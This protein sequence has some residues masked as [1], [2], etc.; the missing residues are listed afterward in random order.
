MQKAV[1]V[2]LGGM[3]AV[4]GVSYQDVQALA[5]ACSDENNLCVAA[6]DNAD[7]QVVL[8]GHMAAIDKAVEIASEF[9][10]KR[11]IKITGQ[12]TVS[13]PVN[14]AGCRSHGSSFG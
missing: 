5:E 8:S 11:C 9:G 7:G 4:I 13:Q 12:R 1:P 14:A 2:G 10:A 6:N 3:A